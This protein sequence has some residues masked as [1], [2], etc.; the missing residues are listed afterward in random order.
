MLG[1]MF[2]SRHIFRLVDGGLVDNVPS[3]GMAVDR[4][5]KIWAISLNSGATVV[6]INPQ[7]TPFTS[8]AHYAL[9]GSAGV[10]LPELIAHVQAQRRL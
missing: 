9:A 1:D 7:Q 10:V 2:A 4:D 3:K 5:G 8:Q 6:E